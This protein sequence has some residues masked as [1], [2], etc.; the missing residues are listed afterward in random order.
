MLKL[1]IQDVLLL[2]RLGAVEGVVCFLIAT[3]LLRLFTQVL[4]GV[5]SAEICPCSS[6]KSGSL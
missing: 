3:V 5:V 1:D 2:Q 4:L 6:A